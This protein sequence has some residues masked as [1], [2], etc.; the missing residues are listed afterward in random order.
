[1]KMYRMTRI[2]PP[3]TIRMASR[4]RGSVRC[5]TAYACVS[6]VDDPV[7]DSEGKRR[8]GREVEE[9]LGKDS[10]LSSS[11]SYASAGKERH[12]DGLTRSVGQVIWDIERGLRVLGT[13]AVMVGWMEEVFMIWASQNTTEASRLWDATTLTLHR[14]PTATEPITKPY[15]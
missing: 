2:M 7:E 8:R 5:L 10:L 11:P 3:R 1:M 4:L 6:L 13:G 15:R 12:G 14:R 9:G